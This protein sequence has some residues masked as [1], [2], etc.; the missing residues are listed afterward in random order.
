MVDKKKITKLLDDVIKPAL[1]SHGGDL[2]LVEITDD[3][4]V[5]VVLEGACKG[6]PMAQMTIRQGVQRKLQ[7]EVPEV[8][9]V[10]AVAA[11]EDG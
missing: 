5:K 8:K 2:Q 11:A 4:V 3:G 1:Q 10:V 9:E 7:E 6:C